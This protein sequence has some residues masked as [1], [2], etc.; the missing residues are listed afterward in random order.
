MPPESCPNCGADVP[1]NARCCPECGADNETGWSDEAVADRLGVSDNFD[2]DEFVKEEFGSKPQIKPHGVR[3]LW[4]V[5]AALLVLAFAW[6][7]LRPFL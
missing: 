4:W 1:S 5:V 7:F 6:A 2:Y 3:W